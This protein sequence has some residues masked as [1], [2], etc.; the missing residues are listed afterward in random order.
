MEDNSNGQENYFRKVFQEYLTTFDLDKLI[1]K[2]FRSVFQ[3]Q[4]F[5]RELFWL[6]KGWIR[7]A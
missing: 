1:Q 3:I 6:G 2:D 7:A 4:T 5:I